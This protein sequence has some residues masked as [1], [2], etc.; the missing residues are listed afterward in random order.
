MLLFKI[1]WINLYSFDN[2][3]IT[4]SLLKIIKIFLFLE[5]ILK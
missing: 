2:S 1:P 4:F 3:L 5:T